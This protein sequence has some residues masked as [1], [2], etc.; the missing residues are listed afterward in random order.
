[1]E[2]LVFPFGIPIL[3]LR[4]GNDG[5]QGKDTG[6]CN[7]KSPIHSLFTSSSLGRQAS[8]QA[9]KQESKQ[10][11]RQAGKRASGQASHRTRRHD[12]TRRNTTRHNERKKK[13]AENPTD[14][15]PRL[16]VSSDLANAVELLVGRFTNPN[17]NERR[18]LEG[19]QV[20]A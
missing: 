1:M 18:G 3:R 6:A 7:K 9:G 17:S 8:K 10:A 16:K 20:E 2:T 15:D 12:A 19:S 14:P 11:S 5:G 13:K 4:K